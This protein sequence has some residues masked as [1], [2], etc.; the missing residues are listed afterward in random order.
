M[1]SGG[2]YPTFPEVFFS[3]KIVSEFALL[4]IADF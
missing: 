1:P 3:E 2:F 4:V